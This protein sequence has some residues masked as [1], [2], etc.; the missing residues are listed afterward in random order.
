MR[1][2][3]WSSDVCSSDLFALGHRAQHAAFPD[4]RVMRVFRRWRDVEVATDRQ[5][6]IFLPLRSQVIVQGLE[7]AQL[8][9]VLLAADCLTVDERD[10]DDAHAID[11]SGDKP[12]RKDCVSGKK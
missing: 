6:W 7:K 9:C 1:I 8:V 11:S 5:Q 10:A 3:D 4:R 2:S 12:D